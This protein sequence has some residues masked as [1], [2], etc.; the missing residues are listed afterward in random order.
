MT[1]IYHNNRSGIDKWKHSLPCKLFG[2]RLQKGGSAMNFSITIDW[3]TVVALGVTTVGTIF[4]MKMDGAAVERVSTHLI[5]A[6][7]AYAIAGNSNR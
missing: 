5:D 7:R 2:V 6:H 3:K 4:A 1:M